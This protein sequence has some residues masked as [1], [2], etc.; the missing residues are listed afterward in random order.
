MVNSTVSKGAVQ[1][2]WCSNIKTKNFFNCINC[3]LNILPMTCSLM[4]DSI[5]SCNKNIVRVTQLPSMDCYTSKG[6]VFLILWATDHIALSDIFIYLI[7][8]LTPYD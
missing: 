5:I 7:N 6:I 8:V 2:V 4:Q 1:I 3:A